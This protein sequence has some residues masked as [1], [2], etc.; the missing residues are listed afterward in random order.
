VRKIA[1]A[2]TLAAALPLMA[3][4]NSDDFSEANSTDLDAKAADVGGA[5]DEIGTAQF[6]VQSGKA[7]TTAVQGW[8]HVV[9]DSSDASVLVEADITLPNTDNYACAINVRFAD[10]SN[11]HF[12]DLIRQSAGTPRM[13]AG[14]YVAAAE[15]ISDEDTD[16]GAITNTT[17]NV[18]V[19]IT[20]NTLTG[21]L[22][23]VQTVQDTGASEGSTNTKH[24]LSSYTGAPYGACQWDNFV[25]D[26]DPTFGGGAASFI[27]G[28]INIPIRG[29]GKRVRNRY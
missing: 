12:V 26:S 20:G 5:W 28:I 27:P 22:N 21:Y 10:A 8:E 1:L 24:G 4:I 13:R 11:Y 14:N 3:V 6:E 18:I 7:T 23:D 19:T 2:F 16:V 9:V 29:G 17:V 15:T 25:I